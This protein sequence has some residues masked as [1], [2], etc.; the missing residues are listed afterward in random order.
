[1]ISRYKQ[2]NKEALITLGLYLFFFLWWTIFAFGFGSDNPETY[3]FILGLPAWFFYSC[4]VGYP[5]I[6]LLLWFV[7]R[8]YFIEMP[9]DSTPTEHGVSKDNTARKDNTDQIVSPAD[10]VL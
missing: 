9:L 10:E 6:T 1:M 7:L 2:A 4:L 8:H 3:T 5:V